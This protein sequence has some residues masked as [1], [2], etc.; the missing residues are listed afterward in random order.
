[1]VFGTMT[2]PR[3]RIRFRDCEGRLREFINGIPPATFVM[4]CD[5]GWGCWCKESEEGNCPS[6]DRS[7][8]G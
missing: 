7:C 3:I 8:D 4:P 1:V 2:D 5:Q 6:W